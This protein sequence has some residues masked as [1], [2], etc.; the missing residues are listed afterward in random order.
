M[1]DMMKRWEIPD[2]GIEKLNLA[3]VERPSP[4]AGEVLVA[5]EAVS[6]N[7]RDL[8]VADDGMTAQLQFP[9]T[10]TSDM[11]GRVVTVGEGVTR[12]VPGDRVISTYIT[13]WI[14]GEPLSWTDSPTQGGPITGMLSQL[15]ATPADWCVRAPASL[16][17][18]EACTLPIAAL[19]G[20][21]ALIELGHLRPGQTVVIQG[22]GGVSLFALQFAVAAGARV[23]VTSSSDAKIARAKELGA[24]HGINRGK[25]PEWQTAV[26]GLTQGR[27][28][29]HI[30]EMA[31][32]ENLK[33][34]LAALAPGG[35]ISV[36]GLLEADEL[37]TPIMPLLA[38]RAQIVAV[39]VGPRR[40][41]E[42]LV[43]M[44]DHHAI[45]PVID[46]VYDFTQVHEA[47]AHLKR[48]AFGKV[49]IKVCQG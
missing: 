35:R 20:W 45:K 47:F 34:S 37:S 42:D 3:T 26:L 17:P 23:I 12:F 21:M 15:V 27:G 1:T 49:V 11:A 8:A 48:G 46:G 25:V 5:V 30:L 33:R 39:A 44:I 7:Y 18:E 16:S 36:I 29:D 13:N 41:L 2:F 31:G 43:R 28:A 6:L 38:S 24:T 9:F 10:P 32:G 14:D 22:T 40:V 4:K 19:T